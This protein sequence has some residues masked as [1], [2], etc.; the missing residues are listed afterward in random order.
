MK[1]DLHTH[2]LPVSRC[3]H[4]QPEELPAMFASAGLGA[5]VLTNHCYPG[6][7]EPLG[8]T[9]GQQARAYVD[10]FERCKQAGDAIGLRVFFGA[11]VKLINEPNRPEFLLYGLKTED[12][13]ASYPLWPLTQQELFDY[14]NRHDILMVQAHPFRQEQGYSPAD[15]RFVHGVEIYNPHPLFPFRFEEGL[16]LADSHG[17]RK[18][19]GSDFHVVSQAGNAGL[20]VPDS[21]TDQFMLRDHLRSSKITVFDR[22]GILYQEP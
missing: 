17:L 13:L 9:P 3:A 1:I 10:I 14:C 19:A 5:I 7:C 18:T 2:C 20:I 8:D 11:E 22:K 6:H 15:M 16:A 4:H 21:I 12:F